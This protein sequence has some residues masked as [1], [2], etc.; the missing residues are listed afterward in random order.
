MTNQNDTL[1]LPDLTDA[2]KAYISLILGSNLDASILYS[3]LHGIYTGVVAVTL[4]NIFMTKSLPVRKAMIVVIILLHI[5]TTIDF[6]LEFSFIHSIFV[7]NAQSIVTKYLFGV[8]PG[9]SAQSVGP[10]ITSVI[11]SILADATI[12]WHCWIVWGQHWLPILLPVLLL[13]SATGIILQILDLLIYLSLDAKGVPECLSSHDDWM[14]NYIGA[15]ASVVKGIAPTLLVGRVAAGHARPDDSWQGSVI[16][17]SIHFGTNSV[18]QDSQLGSITSDNLE[19]Q[20]AEWERD[21]EYGHRARADSEGD[22]SLQSVVCGDGPEVQLEIPDDSHCYN[23]ND[24]G[25]DDLEVHPNRPR[26]DDLHSIL[27]VPRY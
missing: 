25:G 2:D 15:V 23:E 16:S 22:T 18:G 24:L 12:I 27:V 20:A 9:S 4:R 5:F 17:G 8:S 6:G 11:C 13:I 3:L 10:G 1:S 14:S 7:D 26:D 21:E 19:A